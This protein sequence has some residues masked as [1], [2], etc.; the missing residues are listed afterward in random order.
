LSELLNSMIARSLFL[1]PV[2][3]NLGDLEMHVANLF[4]LTGGDVLRNFSYVCTRPFQSSLDSSI[5]AIASSAPKCD[6]M[7]LNAFSYA[8]SRRRG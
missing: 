8:P 4:Q 6:G 5:D 1:Q 2:A 7:K 3:I